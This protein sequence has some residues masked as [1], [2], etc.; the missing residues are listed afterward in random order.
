MI[1]NFP[2]PSIPM[3]SPS[4][5]LGIDEGPERQRATSRWNSGVSL[6]GWRAKDRKARE[7]NE[8]GWPYLDTV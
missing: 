6:L 5:N 3:A 4:G 8:T 2:P 1:G 7:G